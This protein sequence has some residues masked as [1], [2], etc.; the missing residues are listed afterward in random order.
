MPDIRQG[1][2]DL[3]VAAAERLL[4]TDVTFL[5]FDASYKFLEGR[6]TNE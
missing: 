3:V 5:E 2:Y 6:V 1:D 4:P